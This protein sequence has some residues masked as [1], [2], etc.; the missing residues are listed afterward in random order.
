AAS[1]QAQLNSGLYDHTPAFIKGRMVD[2]QRGISSW[3]QWAQS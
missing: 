3:S 2:D 1:D